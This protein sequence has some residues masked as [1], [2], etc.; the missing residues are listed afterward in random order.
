MNNYKNL[1]SLLKDIVN[2][3]STKENDDEAEVLL[4]KILANIVIEKTPSGGAATS[5]ILTSQLDHPFEVTVFEDSN[6]AGIPQTQK[7]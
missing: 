3:P 4:E 1:I 6:G 5:L 7:L 2:N